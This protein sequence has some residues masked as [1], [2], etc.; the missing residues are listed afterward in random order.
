[1][2]GRDWGNYR[3]RRPLRPEQ[4]PAAETGARRTRPGLLT[5]L[6]A[7][8]VRHL[9]TLV[10]TLGRLCRSPGSSLMTA[11]VIG[12]ALALPAAMHVLLQNAGSLAGSWEGVNRVSVFM[13]RDIDAT[14]AAALREE[15]AAREGIRRV[16][17][18]SA[19]D[20]L[21]EFKAMSGFA[22]ALAVLEE[23]PLPSVLVLHPEEQV[24]AAELET[25]VADLQ[26]LGGVDLVQV[27]TQWV[28]RFHAMLEIAA[29]GVGVIAAL[30]AFAVIITVGNTIRLEIQNR[31]QEIEVTKL[32][33]ATDAF[34]RRPFL[35][36][37]L[38]Y[39]LA[40]GA[41]AWMLVTASVV[42]LH[43]PV[44]T[45]A[46]LYGSQFRLSGLGFNETGMVLLAG[47]FLGWA[48]SWVAVSRHLKDIEPG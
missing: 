13:E 4:R 5:R 8:P 23:N 3:S 27:D 26:G 20:A 30:L 47:A 44:R 21:A 11:G 35:Y 19:E 32:V 17:Y 46:G 24:S 12:V 34:I 1:M 48:G 28:Q 33:G 37:G 39:G 14:R 16:E 45:L 6:R 43:D 15:M 40:G 10:F 31:R 29:R 18:I 2:Q 25:L 42:L 22:D 7:W 38:W 41:I 9:Q 36:S